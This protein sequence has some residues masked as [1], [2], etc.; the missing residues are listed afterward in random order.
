MHDPQKTD[1][2]GSEMP[3]WRCGKGRTAAFRGADSGAFGLGALG[4]AA[5]LIATLT[6]PG[7]AS[8]FTEPENERGFDPDKVYQMG[9][10]DHVSMFN[11]NVLV[12]LPVGGGL[13]LT[14]NSN[15]WNFEH[16]S[17]TDGD[18]GQRAFTRAEPAPGFDAGAGWTVLP[19]Q[20]QRP[21]TDNNQ[22]A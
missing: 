7:A 22:S 11:G 9:E 5:T 10:V 3:R 12:T 17:T 8:A 20:L 18:P 19:G 2:A 21:S 6:L 15:L 4:V 14:Y 13:S 1:G 16:F